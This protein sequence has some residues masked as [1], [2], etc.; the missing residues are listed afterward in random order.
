M[1]VVGPGTTRLV[2]LRGA[3]ILLLVPLLHLL[4]LLLLSILDGLVLALVVTGYVQVNQPLK[5]MT[6]N[7]VMYAG[8][9]KS[10]GTPSP[11]TLT[12]VLT[13]NGALLIGATSNPFATGYNVTTVIK[14]DSVMNKAPELAWTGRQATGVSIFRWG[15]VVAAQY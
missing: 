10:N 11:L 14:T 9:M 6:V 3:L 8:Q 1:R 7:G 2:V 15:P 5:I 12:S 13:V 4:C